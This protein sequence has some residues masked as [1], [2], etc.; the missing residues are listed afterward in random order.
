MHLLHWQASSL[1][2]APPGKPRTSVSHLTNGWG[3]SQVKES[4]GEVNGV[5]HGNISA[6][7]RVW[8]RNSIHFLR[9]SEEGTS[10]VVQWLRLYTPN[11]QSP[12]CIPGQG[13]K[14]HKPQLRVGMSQLKILLLAKILAFS[15]HQSQ[16][17]KYRGF[18]GNRKVALVLSRWR[19][20]QHRLRPQELTPP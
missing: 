9:K 4:V 5:I 18:G 15:A 1:P 20:K 19:G 6:W 10:L 14:S 11:A 16:M 12:G 2:T 7:N 13:T 3:K 8:F 17:K